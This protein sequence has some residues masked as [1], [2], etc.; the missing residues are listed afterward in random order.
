MR[1]GIFGA[2]AV[3]GH[4]AARLA[5][6][7]HEV[8][9]IARGAHLRAMQEKGVRLLHGAETIGGR[10]RGAERSAELGTQDLVFVTLKANLLETFARDCAALLGPHTGVVFAQ[11]GIPWWYGTGLA[12]ERRGPPNL[13]PLDPGG[14]LSRAVGPERVMGGVIYS[15][16]EVVEPGVVMNKVPGNNML[17]VGEADDAQSE[18]IKIVRDVLERSGMSSPAAPDIRAAIWAK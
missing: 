7:G 6:S 2:G 16:N 10:V 9:V 14:Q 17:V 4:L 11:N 8:S 12:R 13:A 15:A 1:I 5:A 3:G 18:R